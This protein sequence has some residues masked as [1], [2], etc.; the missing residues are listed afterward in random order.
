MTS[1]KCSKKVKKTKQTLNQTKHS[2]GVNVQ[3]AWTGHT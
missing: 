1:S 2:G 3:C